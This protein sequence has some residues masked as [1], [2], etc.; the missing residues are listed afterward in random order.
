M[1]DLMTEKLIRLNQTKQLSPKLIRNLRER[2]IEI[3]LF[4]AALSS[5]A[6][7]AAI[8]FFLL[9]EISGIFQGILIRLEK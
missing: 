1:P 6:T 9:R 7:M 3:L 4:L 2:G 8:I 5:V